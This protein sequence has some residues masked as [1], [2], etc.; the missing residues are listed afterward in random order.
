M[1]DG[2][3]PDQGVIRAR[4]DRVAWDELAASL[5]EVG[6]AGTGPLADLHAAVAEPLPILVICELLGVSYERAATSGHPQR[7]APVTL[8]LSNGSTGFDTSD[9]RALR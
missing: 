5:D 3:R 9:V 4:V 1:R 8:A 2:H 7:I 6:M